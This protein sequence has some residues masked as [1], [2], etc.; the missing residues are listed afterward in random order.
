MRRRFRWDN[1]TLVAAA[2]NQLEYRSVS[3]SYEPR[4]RVDKSRERDFWSRSR[5]FSPAE[6]YSSSILTGED[7]VNDGSSSA[8]ATRSTR[9]LTILYDRSSSA[10]IWRILV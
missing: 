3:S 5:P 8:L 7:S 6:T 9:R 2:V 10:S 4:P 1:V